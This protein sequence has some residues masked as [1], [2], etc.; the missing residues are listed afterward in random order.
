MGEISTATHTGTR[1]ELYVRSLSP[2]EGRGPQSAVLETLRHL[3]DENRI[4]ELSVS[5]WGRQIA[6]STTAAQTDEGRAILETIESFRS[7]ARATDRSLEPLLETREITSSVRNETR[8]SL[9]LPTILLAE[10]DGDGE[11]I[12][13]T[14][15]M[16]DGSVTTVADRLET[17]GTCHSHRNTDETPPVTQ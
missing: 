12:H 10:Y 16:A 13:V 5:I 3:E 1:V 17:L 15:H 8:V 6:L 9:V 7:W 2:D 14:P 4:D 11:L